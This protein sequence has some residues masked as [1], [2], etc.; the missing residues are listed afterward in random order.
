MFTLATDNISL[1]R[2]EKRRYR[3]D[4]PND[5]E[6]FVEYEHIWTFGAPS[7]IHYLKWQNGNS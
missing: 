3:P 6:L 5:Y 2:N 1:R 7:S 4:F